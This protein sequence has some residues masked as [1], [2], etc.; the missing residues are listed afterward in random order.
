MK[1]DSVTKEFLREKSSPADVICW[2]GSADSGTAYG[3][4]EGG[5]A[6]GAMSYAF[7]KVLRWS[8]F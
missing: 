2:S 7:L 5:I 4:R 1:S 6:V 8:S 3:E